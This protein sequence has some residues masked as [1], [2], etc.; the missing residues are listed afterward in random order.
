ARPRD[1]GA[2]HARAH[3]RTADSS[4]CSRFDKIVPR[5]SRTHVMPGRRRGLTYL[6]S[7]TMMF[8]MPARGSASCGLL[9]RGPVRSCGLARLVWSCGLLGLI[10]GERPTVEPSDG[11]GVICAF[12]ELA[13]GSAPGGAAPGEPGLGE[14]EAPGVVAAP[15]DP[16]LGEPGAPWLAEP[17]PV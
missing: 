14:P 7:G 1:I 15:G 13:F 8:G 16:G 5:V 12:G 6:R 11:A 4:H 10:P 17:P 3:V 9:P 2:E